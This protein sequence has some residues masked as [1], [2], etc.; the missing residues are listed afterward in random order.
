[1]GD[2]PTLSRSQNSPGTI[3]S[4]QAQV[5]WPQSNIQ[6][7]LTSKHPHWLQQVWQRT[8]SRFPVGVL[9]VAIASLSV[10]AL[11]L[12]LRQFDGLQAL[13]LKVFDRM[14]RLRPDE[15]T[16]P[17]LLIVGIAESDIRALGQLRPSDQT[18]AKALQNLE[19]HQPQVIGLDIYRDVP[20]APGRQE[21]QQ[22]LRSPR[23]V[24]ITNLGSSSIDRI[25]PPANVPPERVG[26]N[27]VLVD[28]DGIVRRN[29]LF[30]ATEEAG[31]TSFALQL[32]LQSLAR[33][34]VTP[35][36]S[37]ANPDHLQ[38]GPV[39]FVPLRSNSGAYQ[40]S[41]DRGYQILLDYR[42]TAQV[43]RM[44][45]L[46]DV[47][48]NQ[49][50]PAWVKDKVVL[51]GYTA[52]SLK[53]LFYTPFSAGEQVR[54]Q[55]PGVELHAHMVSQVLSAVLDGRPMFW[56][57][58][59]EQEWL[60]VF[61]WSVLGGAI[62]WLVRRPVVLGMTGMALV[63]GVA[64]VSF[65]LFLQR[66]WV[67]VMA[68]AIATIASLGTVVTYRAQQAHRQQQMVM[69]L[70][71]QN[72]SPEIADAL[73][74]CRDRLLQSGKLPGQRLTATMMFTDIRGFST[75]AEQYPPEVLL[76]WLNDYLAAMTQEVQNHHGIINKFTG[77]GLLAV[78]GVPVPR[79]TRQE[80]ALDAYRAIACALATGQRLA[81][82]NQAW[83]QRN[84]PPVQMRVGIFTGPVVAGSLG[85]K[86]RMEYGL[87]GD[88]VNT[89]ARLESCMKE[90]Q[91]DL[92]RILIAQDTLQYVK[93]LF[94]VESWGPVALK[95]KQQMVQVYRV[96]NH[97]AGGGTILSE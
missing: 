4:A 43:A 54:H 2:R 50:D 27:D 31:Y 76:E 53:D 41:D 86:D 21:L 89:A 46:S 57:W 20:L 38:L 10:T 14:M 79:T 49:I 75:I 71:G 58:T 56:F 93:D 5:R 8:T 7:P 81:Q 35:A 92:C 66:G 42:S 68:P 32:A 24:V 77:D 37:P 48:S 52:P 34:G 95:G 67:P 70:L 25:P 64:V 72:T 44:V 91:P 47:L 22:Q 94:E 80:I 61:A 60:W 9:L 36:A 74:N 28:S 69:T 19:R 11:V 33:A 40:V 78:F 29:L 65:G 13:E 51:M 73:W 30:A 3:P 6:N 97:A 39:E 82:L 15:G 63:M 12:T 85:G 84:L 90:R 62:A 45:T 1:M 23:I 59:E 26:F 96:L 16:D 88:S 18:L 83:Q 87:I 17:R 55:M